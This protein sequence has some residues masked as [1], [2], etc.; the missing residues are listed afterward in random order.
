MEGSKNK[1]KPSYGDAAGGLSA[2]PPCPGTPSTVVT[3]ASSIASLSPQ[4]QPNQQTQPPPEKHR[5]KVKRMITGVLPR[6]LRS[7]NATPAATTPPNG[8]YNPSPARTRGPPACPPGRGADTEATFAAATAA[9]LKPG[10]KRIMETFG[11]LRVGVHRTGGER[12]A[13]EV[14]GVEQQPRPTHRSDGVEA[15]RRNIFET[16]MPVS[17]GRTP[18]APHVQTRPQQKMGGGRWLAQPVD[19]TVVDA[20]DAPPKYCSSTTPAGRDICVGEDMDVDV[21]EGRRPRLSKQERPFVLRNQKMD[22]C[23]DGTAA[24]ADAGAHDWGQLLSP[25]PLLPVVTKSIR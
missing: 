5:E 6:R 24:A 22:L 12:R 7:S 11:R 13:T 21:S 20:G 9:R 4:P 10:E 16:V 25:P 23:C 17:S 15:K 19:V 1:N 3:D 18:P 14:T 8:D 2:F